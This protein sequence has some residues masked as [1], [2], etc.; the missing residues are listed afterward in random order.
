MS[1]GAHIMQVGTR[2]SK[3]SIRYEH[4]KCVQKANVIK[5]AF[6][7]AIPH[8]SALVLFS[9]SFIWAFNGGAKRRL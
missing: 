2:R 6:I 7:L 1:A 4:T 8:G 9:D 5:I 3:L